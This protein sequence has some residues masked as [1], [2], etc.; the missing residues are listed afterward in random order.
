EG[1]LEIQALLRAVVSE[2]GEVADG[3]VEPDVE[4]LLLLDVRHADAEVG[5][6]ARD[7]PVSERLV[8]PPLQPFLRLVHDLRLQPARL[9]EP[10]LDE[11]LAFRVGELE[12]VVLR[13]P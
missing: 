6:I 2:R 12:E 11:A 10:A 13:G 4:I 1:L 3:R 7:V 5:R 8:A 9:L